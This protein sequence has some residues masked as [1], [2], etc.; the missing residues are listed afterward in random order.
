MQQW[1]YKFEPYTCVDIG[2]LNKLGKEGWQLVH[3][4]D[5]NIYIFKRPINS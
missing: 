4:V 2:W 5:D 3:V 1:E